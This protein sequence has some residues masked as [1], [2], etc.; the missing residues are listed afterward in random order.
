MVISEQ[1]IKLL[2]SFT[3]KDKPEEVPKGLSPE[4]YHTLDYDSE[5]KIATRIQGI[6]DQLNSS[7]NQE[8]YIK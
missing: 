8:D 4:F 3:P 1:D 5:V 6:R 2:L 7:D